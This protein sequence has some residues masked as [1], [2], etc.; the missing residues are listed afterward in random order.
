MHQNVTL[1][2]F[3]IQTLSMSIVFYNCYFI[4]QAEQV[5]LPFICV[6]DEHAE[7][8]SLHF[9]S[10]ELGE[11]KFRSLHQSSREPTDRLKRDK[12]NS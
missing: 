12:H 5:H 1:S 9:D 8:T 10:S 2:S 3:S 11:M 7:G 6:S 4:P